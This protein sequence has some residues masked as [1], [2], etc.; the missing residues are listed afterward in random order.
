MQAKRELLAESTP[1]EG[2]ADTHYLQHNPQKGT[3]V[4]IYDESIFN[5]AVSSGKLF[6]R[7]VRE[8]KSEGLMDLLDA[9]RAAH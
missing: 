4:T 3:T 8:G 9:Y 2:R 1:F 7:K 5:E 6:I